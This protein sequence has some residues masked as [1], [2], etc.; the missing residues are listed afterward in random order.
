M[1]SQDNR[2]MP[3]PGVERGLERPL[4]DLGQVRSYGPAASEPSQ[5]RDYLFIVLKRKWLI[6]SLCLVVTSLVAI[7]MFRQ[8]SIY[9]AVTT[10]KIEQRAKNVLQTKDFVL[11]AQPDAN[12]WGTQ[13]KLLESPT[14]ARQVALTLDLQNNQQFFGSQAQGGIFAALKRMVAG[15]ARKPTKASPAEAPKGLSVVGETR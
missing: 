15:D 8:P 7:Q 6:L 2:L 3:M 11:N 4:S 10:I 12:F 1:M 5:I 9:E 13:I 14:L